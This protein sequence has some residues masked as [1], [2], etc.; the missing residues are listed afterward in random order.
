MVIRP[1]SICLS[2]DCGSKRP[3]VICGTLKSYMYAGSLA[4][5]TVAIG[6]K[7]MIIDQYNPRDAQHFKQAEKVEV[8]IPRSVHLLKKK[9]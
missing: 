6:D 9:K 1:E 3:N 4:K 8:E 5:C 2:L 7:K